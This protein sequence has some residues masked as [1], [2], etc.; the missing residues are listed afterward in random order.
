MPTRSR[1]L[2][3][4]RTPDDRGRDY[5]YVESPSTMERALREAVKR[6]RVK[7]EQQ[8]D[9][10]RRLSEIRRASAPGRGKQKQRFSSRPRT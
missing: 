1:H 10:I 8:R 7:L 2:A 4:H 9:E 3:S 6:N 5:G